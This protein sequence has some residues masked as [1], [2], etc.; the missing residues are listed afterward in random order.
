MILMRLNAH[1]DV[2]RERAGKPR[3][4]PWAFRN[5]SDKTNIA[6]ILEWMRLERGCT[7]GRQW[8]HAGSG[9]D[10][11]DEQ[12]TPHTSSMTQRWACA[13]EQSQI[14][15]TGASLPF[16][17]TDETSYCK[18]QNILLLSSSGTMQNS[19]LKGTVQRLP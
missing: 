1:C 3:L 4:C 12:G 5:L 19:T 6:P 15:T 16:Y 11:N 18:A 8:C 7:K 17:R 13:T 9:T 10:T 2:E 14:W